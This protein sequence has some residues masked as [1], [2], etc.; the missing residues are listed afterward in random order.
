MS[1]VNIT[2]GDLPT[3]VV[4]HADVASLQRELNK[5]G[6][7]LVV[8]GVYGNKTDAAYN[9]YFGS[10]SGSGSGGSSG[11]SSGGSS[12]G[13]SGG[14]T[15][16]PSGYDGPV[17][18]GADGHSY[19]EYGALLREDGFFYPAGAKISPNGMYFDIGNGWQFAKYGLAFDGGGNVLGYTPNSMTYAAP[20]T[21]VSGFEGAYARSS[22]VSPDD[23]NEDGGADAEEG[24]SLWEQYYDEQRRK[25]EEE[26]Y[27]GY[28]L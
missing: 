6:A 2:D 9:Q 22:G 14:N 5:N 16:H 1:R 12:G 24:L 7:N 18:K 10:S 21:R 23:G 4:S 13:A 3:G 8:D 20:G 26:L 17:V 19:T 27:A 11:R 25:H 28:G 15:R